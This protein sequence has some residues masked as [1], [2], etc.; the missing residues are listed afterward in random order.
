MKRALSFL[1]GLTVLACVLVVWDTH[2][3]VQSS[4]AIFYGQCDS[5]PA[6]SSSPYYNTYYSHYVLLLGTPTC[7]DYEGTDATPSSSPGNGFV[8]IPMPSPGTLSNLQLYTY[9]GGPISA[10]VY[11]NNT[12]TA[13]TCTTPGTG[14]PDTCGDATDTVLV[15]TGD[16]V[17][18]W[19]HG[20]GTSISAS[21]EKQ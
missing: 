5:N 12:A 10:T 17:A 4:Y 6:P 1:L 8:G 2:A 9:S 11:V 16:T 19:E 21:F 3:R 14:P 7:D 20:L 13:L 18:L 15:N